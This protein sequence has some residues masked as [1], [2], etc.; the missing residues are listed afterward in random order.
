MM[1]Q[2]KHNIP[3]L[4]FP[5]FSGEWEEKKLG[6][7]LVPTLREIDKPETNYLAIGIRSHCKGTFQKPNSEPEKIAMEK[8][9]VVREN[10][11]I[12]NITFAWEGALAIARKE[13]DGGLV[14]HRFPTY[15][16]NKEIMTN[17]F[18]Q[19]IFIN[20]KFIGIMELI[21]P[22]G[23]GRNRV[24]NKNSLLKVKVNLPSTPEQTK[25]ANFLTEVDNLIAKLQEKKSLLE[26]YKSGIMQQ[27]FTQQIRFT[28]DNGNS[29]PDWE[30]KELGKLLDYEQP[31]KY[32][33]TS[34]DYDDFYETPVLTAGKSFILGYTNE[35][36]GIYKNPLPVII[37]DD[38]TT[39]KKFVTFSFK[40]KSSAMKILLAK[41]GVNIKYIYE[42]MQHINYVVG[43]HERHWISKYSKLTINLPEDMDEQEKIAN[44]LT[45]LYSKIEAVEGQITEI[46][47]F[48]K[49]LLQQMFV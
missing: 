12:I 27:I 33:V 47:E 14:S 11:F 18:F 48:K 2:Q 8:L 21:S 25:I 40:V 6:D 32:I 1:S 17:N 26:K 34:T 20:K 22:G 31:T 42:A 4:R 30:E 44:F 41:N 45:S 7:F 10:D 13:D 46:Q 24:L 28:D 35:T 49:G 37:F 3:E 15:I 43:G 19:Y 36:S 39:A 29:Y 38:F 9:Y 16:F 23:A 5:E